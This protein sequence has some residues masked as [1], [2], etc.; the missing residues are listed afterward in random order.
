[1][2]DNIDNI[3]IMVDPSNE[4]SPH[5]RAGR[6]VTASTWRGCKRVWAEKRYRYGSEETIVVIYKRL[7]VY[8]PA[9]RDIQAG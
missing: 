5:R 9:W 2:F 6:G 3:R 8:D 7:C 4:V 1:M